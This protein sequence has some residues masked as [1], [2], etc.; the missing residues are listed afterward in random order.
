MK[1]MKP[2]KDLGKA[3]K[4][5]YM[6]MFMTG[7][8]IKEHFAPF[9]L[10]KKTVD[11]PEHEKA[12]R[13]DIGE[14][15]ETDN[16]LWDR[17]LTEAKQTGEQRYGKDAFA[18]DSRGAW[19]SLAGPELARRGIG[20]KTSI[21]SV[22]KTQGLSGYIPLQSE[23]DN[24]H[25]ERRPILGGHHRIALSAEQFKDHIFPIKYHSDISEATG[26]KGYQ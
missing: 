8:E 7:P 18:R 9:M 21:E 6:P 3:L 2:P 16:E 15:L 19:R 20:A 24:A 5:G 12:N 1:R 26:E 23:T 11:L 10:D 22:A 17:K 13:Y 25:G 4:A 14:R